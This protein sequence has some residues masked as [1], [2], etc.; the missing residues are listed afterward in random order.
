[1]QT[2]VGVGVSLDELLLLKLD[3]QCRKE[4]LTRSEVVGKAVEQYL[5]AVEQTTS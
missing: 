4:N 3:K 1:M 5:S 2:K